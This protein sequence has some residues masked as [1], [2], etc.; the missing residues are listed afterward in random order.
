MPSWNEKPH[1]TPTINAA[2][3]QEIEMK[4]PVRPNDEVGTFVLNVVMSASGRIVRIHENGDPVV[5]FAKRTIGER[6]CPWSDLKPVSKR[7]S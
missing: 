6:V 7:R 5:K 4:A 3:P 2:M 1:V